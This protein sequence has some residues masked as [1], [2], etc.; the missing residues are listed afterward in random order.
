MKFPY[1]ARSAVC[2]CLFA[3]NLAASFAAGQQ[4]QTPDSKQLT[5][6]QAQ[7][8]LKKAADAPAASK[9][10]TASEIQGLVQY[11]TTHK[12]AA[13]A[14]AAKTQKAKTVVIG[15]V[16][17]RADLGPGFQGESVAAP[18]RAML[19]RNLSGP[20]VELVPIDGLVSQ[21]IDAE[22]QAKHCDYVLYSAVSQ[23]KTGGMGMG[24]FKGA[25]TL[26]NV[27]P[28]AAAVKAASGTMAAAGTIAS[29]A[30]A[31]QEAGAVSKGV[32]AKS[33]VSFEYKLQA[34]GNPTTVLS[35][36]LKA[37]AT[38]DGEDVMTPL[39]QQVAEA[40]L[41]QITKQ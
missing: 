16:L 6:A 12:Q 25:T 10:L 37:K 23:K 39:V 22:S 32:K 29:A 19:T 3:V 36:T 4:K 15:L 11:L 5:E 17:P 18:L 31:A 27:M 1:Q 8:L 34:S 14:E 24:L 35:N 13:A 7:A 21:Q 20:L 26:A 28:G 2:C 30:E 41:T 38:S 40:V 9:P 33:E